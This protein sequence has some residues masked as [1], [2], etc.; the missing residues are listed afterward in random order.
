MIYNN[1]RLDF[2]VLG[3]IFKKGGGMENQKEQSIEG[4]AW[5]LKNQ[6]IKTINRDVL[7]MSAVDLKELENR[8]L[9]FGA[10]YST[11]EGLHTV[12]GDLGKIH[13]Y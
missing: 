9:S 10:I 4:P 1:E 12:C 3:K 11:K 13:F 8:R 6:N 2:F 5:N 7:E